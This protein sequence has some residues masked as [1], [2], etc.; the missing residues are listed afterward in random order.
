MRKIQ[1]VLILGLLILITFSC[2]EDVLDD[3]NKNVNDPTDVASNLII[4]DVLTRTAFTITG[5]DLA[6]YSS[7][8]IEHN[9][10]VWNQSY[11]AEI[12]TGEPVSSTTYNNS[13]N[14]IY[15][16]LSD[17]KLII[18]KCSEG[19]SE[20]GNYHTL[21]IAQAMNAY[22]LAILTD[23]MGDV[24]WTEALQPGVIFT[25]KLDKQEE[26]YTEIF[27]LLD[28][29]IENLQ[30][31]TLFPSLGAQD[32]IYAGNAQKWLKFAYGLKARYTMRLSHR[33]P[34]YADVIALANQ[35]FASAADECKYTYNAATTYSPFYRFFTD[36]DYFGAS[37]SLADKLSE[38]NDPRD[39]I[40][41]KTHPAAG[42]FEFAPNGTPS[43]VQG[44]YAISAISTPTAPTFLL[45]YHEIEFLKAEAYVRS[46]DLDAAKTALSN[47]ISAAF[48]KVNIGLSSA[49][50]ETYF[51]D[52][53]LP[54][55][56]AKP[57][58]EVMNQKYIAFFE[59]EAVEAYNDY[60]RLVAMG[61]NVIELANPFNSNNN[62]PQ[63]FTY[64]ASDVT[65]NANVRDAYGDGTY[66]F[67]EK[68]WWAGGTR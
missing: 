24:P 32:F 12:R 14:S 62:F 29:S 34:A 33:T 5:S 64:G 68:V 15:R 54:K 43:Q 2:S 20:D 28:A 51:N 44:R 22:T 55:F 41:W 19:G 9:V 23:L 65:T 1:N 35:S 66:V 8:Y 58:E 13:W 56:N 60:R 11:N 40:F 18:N 67:S 46:N 47:A 16:N 30:K 21:G 17:I 50:A 53:V 7:V 45:S 39:T 57:L 3:I 38:R 10:G 6:F 42:E 48:Q 27:Q 36:R 26:L 59:E 61:N 4:S 37:Q 52:Q 49:A 31:T 63:R 25:P